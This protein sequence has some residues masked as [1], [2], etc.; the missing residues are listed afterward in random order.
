MKAI[1]IKRDCEFDTQV[2]V[3]LNYQTRPRGVAD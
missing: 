2:Y 3:L 1:K